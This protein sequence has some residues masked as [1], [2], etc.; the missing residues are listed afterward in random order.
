MLISKVLVVVF[1]IISCHSSSN[2]EPFLLLDSKLFLSLVASLRAVLSLFNISNSAVNHFDPSCCLV[3]SYF[4]LIVTLRA[5]K[6]QISFCCMVG[7]CFVV[8]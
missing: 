6:V 5:V 3:E 4:R 1:E 7:N 8:V 2:F